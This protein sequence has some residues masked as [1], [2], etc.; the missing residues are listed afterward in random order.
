[1]RRTPQRR[2]AL[3]P[4]R[5]A[6]V[7]GPLLAPVL[8]AAIAVFLW[9]PSAPGIGPQP[10]RLWRGYQTLAVRADVVKSRGAAVIAARLGPGVIC[11]VT[12]TAEFW[13]FGGFSRVSY[14]ALDS[15]LDPLDPRRDRYVEGAARYFHASGAGREWWVAYLPATRPGFRLFLHTASMLGMPV[16][17][18]WRLAEFDPL[19]KML[20]LLAVFG[21]AVLLAISFDEARRVALIVALIAAFL[22]TPFLLSGSI[23]QLAVC[24]IVLLSWFPLLR[25]CLLLRRW[26]KHLFRTLQKPL[27]LFGCVAAASL[28]T[29]SLGI[30]FSFSR[31]L[32]FLSP[33][34]ASL[35]V[36]AVIPAVSL[37]TAAG[38]RRKRI[39]QPVPIVRPA[40]DPLRGRSAALIVAPLALV[41]IAL[42]SLTRGLA[43]PTPHAVLGA[44]SFSWHSLARL[45]RETGERQLPGFAELV[46]HDAFQETMPF[47]RAWKAPSRDERVTVRD[48]AYDPSTGALSARKRTVKVFDSTWLSSVRSRVTAG[49][50]EALLYAQSRPVVVSVRGAGY[51]LLKELPIVLLVLCALLAWLGKDLGLGPLIRGNLLRLNGA[52]RRDQV[53]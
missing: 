32:D 29:S 20:S 2:E 12:A 16:R 23:A 9:L 43:L 19:E 26:D 37:L 53:P 39:F 51:G 11:D 10:A 24:L 36:L 48:F 35:L 1:M 21:F 25:A 17:G 14:A 34:V 6:R 40:L 47:G 7:L 42:L 33:I 22:W 50:L 46:T 31:L 27:L 45:G 3:L 44:G 4:R 15:R 13:D 41:F 49:S 18:Q 28:A 8:A 38:G 30:G 5:K 52:A